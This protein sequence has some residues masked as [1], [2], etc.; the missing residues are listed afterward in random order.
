MKQ[1]KN[2]CGYQGCN[3]P[4][5]HNKNGSISA[6]P[7]PGTEIKTLSCMFCHKPVGSW[8]DGPW[9]CHCAPRNL[10]VNETPNRSTN[11]ADL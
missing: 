2:Q 6:A 5:G 3:L 8:P 1:R 10:S 7:P 9:A 11:R 4:R